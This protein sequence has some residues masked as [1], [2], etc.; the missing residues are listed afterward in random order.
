MGKKDDVVLPIAWCLMTRRR[1]KDY[2]ALFSHLKEKFPLFRPSLAMTDFERGLQNSLRENFAGISVR[3]CHFHL[4]QA[5]I[6]WIINILNNCFPT[7]FVPGNV[8]RY[9]HNIPGVGGHPIFFLIPRIFSTYIHV[10]WPA[11]SI[12]ASPEVGEFEFRPNA[13]FLSEFRPKIVPEKHPSSGRGVLL[14]KIVSPSSGP[15]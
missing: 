7:K 9:E 1:T 15:K 6:I 5:N 14:L 13:L 8:L 4:S 11:E 12:P 10:F 3:G 2:N